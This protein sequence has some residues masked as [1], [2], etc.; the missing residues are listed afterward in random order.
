MPI[1]VQCANCERRFRAPD[2]MTGKTGK[3][4]NCRSEIT[5]PPPPSPSRTSSQ[6][7]EDVAESEKDDSGTV[8]RCPNCGKSVTVPSS[9]LG[10]TKNCPGCQKPF[11]LGDFDEV[12][13]VAL[14]NQEAIGTPPVV[15]EID[16]D[17]I[18]VQCPK[19]QSPNSAHKTALDGYTQ[20]TTCRH[21]FSPSKTRAD[22]KLPKSRIEKGYRRGVEGYRR[23]VEGYRRGME[24][25]ARLRHRLREGT[26]YVVLVGRQTHGLLFVMISFIAWLLNSIYVLA[27]DAKTTEWSTLGLITLLIGVAK[28]FAA[29]WNIRQ[30]IRQDVQVATDQSE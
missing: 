15:P 14:R 12:V 2:T 17:T 19:C 10:Q 13:D 20:C 4:P 27:T 9:L 6:V 3:C 22:K 7:T 18:T 11:Q 30:K 26:P 28:Y 21:T 1:D 8:C 5:I 24:Y 23:G 25:E 29:G 16:L